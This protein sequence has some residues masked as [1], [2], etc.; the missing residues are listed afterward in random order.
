MPTFT[1]PAE[2]CLAY[3]RHGNPA[4]PP[5]LLVHGWLSHKGVWASTIDRL[6]ATHYCI[7]VDLL[8]FGESDKPPDAAY[9]IVAQA[10]RVLE[11]ADML[12]W[13]T[14]ALVGHSM[15]GQIATYI[16]AVAA[17]H[18]VT[19]LIAV[20]PVVTGQLSRDVNLR[21]PLFE[22]ARYVPVGYAV[23]RVLGRWRFVVWALN[24]VAWF[25]N[26]TVLPREIWHDESQMFYRPSMRIS[27]PEAG[28]SIR[29]TALTPHLPDVTAKAMVIFGTEDNTAPCEQGNIF[30]EGVPSAEQVV[31]EACGHFPMYEGFGEYIAVVTR[32]LA[33]D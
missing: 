15:G 17:P 8:G 1:N 31:I 21:T 14:F 12:G 6:Q 3:T 20:A 13:D 24:G 18:R 25:R 19:T 10:K 7:A 23:A 28:R 9:S 32:F 22:V 2:E 27:I 26:I 29:Q 16:A 4:N 30:A 5:L 33:E 11:V